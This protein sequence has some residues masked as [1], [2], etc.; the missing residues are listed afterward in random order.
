KI[1]G[2]TTTTDKGAI[3]NKGTLQVS[4]LATLLNDKLT[5]DTTASGGIIQ[6]DAN[7]TL[8]LSGTE[9]V[10]G[11]ITDGGII[12]VT[13]SSKIDGN[14]RLH[15]GR[16]AG[17][18]LVTLTLDNVAVD[19]STLTEM[20]SGSLIQVDGGAS[21]TLKGGAKI[22]GSTTTTDKGAISNK[23]TLEVSGLATLLNDKLTNDTTASGGIIQVDAN[24]TLKVAG[25]EIVGGTIT[26]GGI[27]DVT[28]SSKIDGASLNNGGVTVDGAQTLTLDNVTV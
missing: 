15:D 5:N 2:S 6:V 7:T 16:L 25:T 9:I 24:T 26:D 21:L 13:G 22:Q 19:G 28:G 17:E 1:Q 4:G 23:G 11:T 8:K 12:D 14:A 18:G 20:T 10:G 27:I 3:S